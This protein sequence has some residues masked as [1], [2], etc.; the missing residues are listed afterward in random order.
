L[1]MDQ[2][3]VPPLVT[4]RPP[5]AVAPSICQTATPGFDVMDGY[6]IR[7][8]LVIAD[9]LLPAV[10]DKSYTEI[11][12]Q[13]GDIAKCLSFYAA[14]VSAVERMRA[15]CRKLRSRG[16]DVVCKDV[17][18]ARNESEL[19]ISD[20]YYWWML[21]GDN[22]VMLGHVACELMRV[23]RSATVYFGMD[24]H[25]DQPQKIVE[26]MEALRGCG[27]W[28]SCGSYR[29]RSTSKLTRLFFDESFGDGIYPNRSQP[30]EFQA[31]YSTPYNGRPGKWGTFHMF[32]VELGPGPATR[33]DAKSR[34]RGRL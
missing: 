22:K 15:N 3:P 9:F 10:R 7:S 11:G 34:C 2:P 4:P 12:T 5:Y 32:S 21:P 30:L 24:T 25:L 29:R 28:H 14:R 13:A 8:P 33:T 26:T 23:Q 19:P 20:V 17:A 27:S 6:P 31:T 1:F 16:I 18:S